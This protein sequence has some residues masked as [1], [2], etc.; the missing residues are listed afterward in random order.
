[1]TPLPPFRP[2]PLLPGG[3]AQTLAATFFPSADGR[4][5]E[6][7]HVL[8]LED[9]DAVVLHDD[10]PHDWL[11]GD[12]A[13]LLVHGLT[14]DHS[15]GYMVRIA[16]RLVQRG[17]R[18]FRKDARGWGAGVRLAK[19]PANAG[20]SADARA[21][22]H[23]IAGM[24]PGSPLGVAGFSLGANIVLKMLGE[25]PDGQ[26]ETLVRA[27]AVNAPIDLDRS[28]CA[29]ETGANRIY[30][31]YF[32]RMLL[33]RL[34]RLR[35]AVP[36]LDW[37]DPPVRPRSLREFDDR[38]TA[39]LSGYRD[40]AD[41]YERASAGP[42]LDRI[43]TPTLMLSAEDD[44][45]V[46]PGMYPKQPPSAA[47]TLHLAPSG[48]HLGYIAKEPGNDPDRRWMDARVVQWLLA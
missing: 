3:H 27:A 7:T 42:L 25:R 20:R 16:R 38:Y 24:C 36:D 47:V 35:E 11:P 33:R 17:A 29:M 10:A 41:Y 45:I 2:H 18:V 44:P 12:P 6:H 31:A 30:D 43:V 37:P 8:R 9:G 26:P 46:P 34:V 23:A 28:L 19:K 1:V 32:T 13:V 22:L 15:S 40:A 39:P 14:G 48:G 4:P 5:G 21:A